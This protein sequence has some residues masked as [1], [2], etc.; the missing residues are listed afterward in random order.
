MIKSISIWNPFRG[1]SGPQE[2]FNRFLAMLL[3]L[4]LL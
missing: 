2:M 4:L 3:L 1:V